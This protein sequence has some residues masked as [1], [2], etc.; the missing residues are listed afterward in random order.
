MENEHVQDTGMVK[1][2]SIVASRRLPK[3]KKKVVNEKNWIRT[4][5]VT[6]DGRYQ[7]S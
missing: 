6:I 4:S 2:V 1:T 5:Q 7:R 3:K